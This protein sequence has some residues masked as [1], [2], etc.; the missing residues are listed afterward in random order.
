MEIDTLRKDHELGIK[1]YDDQ[2]IKLK[3][4]ADKK[5]IEVGL[6]EAKLRKS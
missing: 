4:L 5:E 1:L 6:L 3:E 2:L